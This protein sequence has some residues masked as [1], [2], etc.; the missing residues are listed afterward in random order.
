MIY[1]KLYHISSRSSCNSSF[2]FLVRLRSYRDDKTVPSLRG[3]KKKERFPL[4]AVRKKPSTTVIC[5]SFLFPFFHT[6]RRS[7]SSLSLVKSWAVV[8]AG[9]TGS[10][11]LVW[12]S[13]GIWSWHC[14]TQCQ[15]GQTPA[16]FTPL[17]ANTRRC[18]ISGHVVN[19]IEVG[20]FFSWTQTGETKLNIWWLNAKSTISW[21]HT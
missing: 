3:D 16:V 21:P 17:A 5:F 7:R 4:M 8:C 11:S 12:A 2:F 1:P 20:L 18:C 6:R 9:D 15:T 13:G 14:Q 10:R 19:C